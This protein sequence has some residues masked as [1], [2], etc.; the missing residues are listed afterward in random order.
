M[1]RAGG[2]QLCRKA[3]VF[4]YFCFISYDLQQLSFSVVKNIQK[5]NLTSKKDYLVVL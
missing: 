1:E 4:Y 3:D 2:K 5:K